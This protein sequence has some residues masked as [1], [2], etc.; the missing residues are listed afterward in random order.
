[1]MRWAR[2]IDT[3]LDVQNKMTENKNQM[4]V[5]EED[6]RDRYLEHIFKVPHERYL[7]SIQPIKVRQE[8][9]GH[10]VQHLQTAH[11]KMFKLLAKPE[12]EENQENNELNTRIGNVK[13][14]LTDS[15]A[16]KKLKQD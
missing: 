10:Y 6:L 3:I 15:P 11:S 8:E 16:F 13:E 14:M 1:M 4:D 5:S 2:Q 9:E 7:R 12:Y